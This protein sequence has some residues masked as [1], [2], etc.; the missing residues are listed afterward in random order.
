M[1]GIVACGAAIPVRRLPLSLLNGKSAKPGS[2]ER[3]LAWSD[4]DVITLAVAAARD[5][6][7]DRDRSTIDLLLFASTTAPYVE[8]LGAAIVAAALALAPGTRT[9]DVTNSLRGGTQALLL[10]IDAV[11][12]GSARSALVVVTDCR[13]GAPGSALEAN[14]GDAAAAFLVGDGEALF[15][16][17]DSATYSAEIV[18]VWRRPGDRFTHSWEERFVLAHGY[19]E[20]MLAAHGLLAQRARFD[21]VA[22]SHRLFSASDRKSHQ[23]L[24]GAL[25]PGAPVQDPLFGSVGACG[26]AHAL[27]QLVALSETAAPGD[28]ALLLN[29]GDGADALGLRF[30]RPAT[31]RFAA[32]LARRLALSGTEQYRR[33]RELLIEEYQGHDFQG[34]SATVHYRDRA[35][36]L[37]LAGQRCVCGEAQFPP[38]RICVRCG[39]ADR[40]EQEIFAERGATLL[41]YTLDAFFPTPEPPTVVAVVQVTGGPRIHVQLTDM[42]ASEVRIGMALEFVLRR[43]HGVGGRPNYFWKCRPQGGVAP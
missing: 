18:D 23:A 16:V 5:C 12:A 24:L 14:G 27:L 6:L 30:E 29:H 10:A 37:A 13:Q 22:S 7:L 17:I 25:G 2:P 4:E 15:E 3:A 8:K 34:I 42:P 41:T 35:A 19:L 1:V 33:A 26:A 39:L 21:V 11:R 28:T 32:R 43:I 9:L 20:P 31:A 38:A 36:N 40:F